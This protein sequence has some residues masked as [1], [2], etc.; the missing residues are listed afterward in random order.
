M[1]SWQRIVLISLGLVVAIASSAYYWL[2][3]ESPAPH[4]RFD[5]DMAEVRRLAGST[6]GSKPLEIRVEHIADFKA[7]AAAMVAG[8]GWQGAVMH[9]LSYQLVYPDHTIIL[10]TAMDAS[11]A[12][13]MGSQVS[14]FNQDA[15]DRMIK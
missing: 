12:K 10:D 8:D 15:Y 6:P 14:G 5:L 4:G 3:Y 7:P 11:Q 2:F 13:A 9:A 1:R